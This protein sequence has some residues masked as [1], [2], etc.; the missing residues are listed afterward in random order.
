MKRYYAVQAAKEYAKRAIDAGV[1]GKENTGKNA[2]ENVA[3]FIETLAS[4]LEELKTDSDN[5]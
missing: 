3:D 5:D 2:A 4:R 1:F